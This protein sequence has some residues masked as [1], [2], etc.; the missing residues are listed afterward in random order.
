M[1]KIATAMGTVTLSNEYFANLVGNA[2]SSCYG[3]VGMV[4][5]NPADGIRSLV[6]GSDFP[7]KGVKVSQ[8]NGKL[9]IEI[10]IKVVYGLNISAIVKSISHKVRYVVESATGLTVARM[11]VSVDEMMAEGE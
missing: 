2:A 3:V 6:F 7:E 8:V 4:N 10:H 9:E 5:K 11:S 1:V